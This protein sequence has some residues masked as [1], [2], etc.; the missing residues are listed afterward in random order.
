M[1][2]TERETQTALYLAVTEL[3]IINKHQSIQY[4]RVRD[5]SGNPLAI[6]MDK[7]CNGKRGITP[8][9]FVDLLF[10][11]LRFLDLELL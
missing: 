9:A 4:A 10:Y 6:P 5:W 7:D 2:L 11:Y 3:L 8:N 1:I